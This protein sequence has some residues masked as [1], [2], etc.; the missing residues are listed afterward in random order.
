[1]EKDHSINGVPGR[2]WV[3]KNPGVRAA[4]CFDAQRWI[5]K[6]RPIEGYGEGG[7]MRV[8]ISFDDECKNGRNTFTITAE[9]STKGSRYRNDIEAGGTMHKEIAR[10]FP[11][12]ASLTQWHLFDTNG[13][14]HYV[15][16]TL[17]HASNRADLRY[18]PGD[19]CQWETRVRFG[20]F[21][22]TFKFSKRFR[23]YLAARIEHT[24]T[25]KKTNPHHVEKF[26]PLA[27]TYVKRD[28][29]ETYEYPPHYTVRG[30]DCKVWH[31]APFANLR[32]AQEFCDALNNYE[33]TFEKVPVSY[34]K[35]KPRNLAAARATANWPD[36]TDEQLCSDPDELKVILLARLPAMMQRFRDAVEKEC[37]FMYE[38][39]EQI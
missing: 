19:P 13:P 21:P 7:E 28:P 24:K 15:E 30:D 29:K 2:M 4:G 6:V 1:M 12:L 22:V 25:T 3:A 5:S 38:A 23:E 14:M 8:E 37:G 32:E 16:N 17:Y 11:E 39:P 18:A 35:E 27:V 26:E 31:E 36:A 20:K 9:V 10:V 33:L 34:A